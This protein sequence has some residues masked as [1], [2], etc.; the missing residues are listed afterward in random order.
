M[1]RFSHS[2]TT[3]KLSDPNIEMDTDFFSFKLINSLPLAIYTCDTDGYIR[4][5]NKAAIKLWGREPKIGADLWCG[6]WKIF[7]ANGEPLALSSCPMARILKEGVV[8]EGEEIIVQ[9]PDGTKRNVIPYPVLVFDSNGILKGAVNTLVDITEQKK[10]EEHKQML[11][12]IIESSHDAIIS[13][14]LKGIVNSWNREAENMFG[15]TAQ[16]VIGKHISIIIPLERLGEENLILSKISNGE[17]LDHFETVRITKDGRKISISLTVSPVRDEKGNVIGASKI[18]RDITNQKL[19]EEKTL[20]HNSNLNILNSMGKT[21]SVILDSQQLL[22]KVTDT[23]TEL[24]KAELGAFFYNTV[25]EKGEA[26]LLKTFSGTS[27]EAF[28]MFEIP[29]DTKILNTIF[30]GEEILRSDD[31]TKDLRFSNNYILKNVSGISYLAVPVFSKSG[32]IVGG[33]FYTHSEAGKF[34]IEHENLVNGVASHAVLALD[35][36]RLFEEVAALN[37][38][39]DEFIGLASHELKTP[40]TSISGYLQILEKTLSINDS[41]KVF[42]K[43]A[44][45]QINKLSGLISDLLDISK[46]HT[47]KLPFSFIVF[48]LLQ[49]IDEIK[50]LMQQSYPSHKIE[51]RAE[52]EKLIIQADKQRIEQVFINLISNAIKYSPN[53][54]KVY[55]HVISLDGKVKISIQDF[56][57][58]IKPEDQK[59]IFEKFYRVKGLAAHFSGLG[60]GLYISNEI[61]SRHNGKLYVESEVGVGS[62]FSFEIP[63]FQ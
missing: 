18:A 32:S 29:P 51:L 9:R 37:L 61:I 63:I 28:G 50:D 10:G 15:Y 25:D 30:Q 6:S 11:A 22:Q 48:D 45:Q 26:L 39:K 35:N 23:T 36:A 54:D 31:I 46:I 13:K 14:T 60:I 57:V 49:L 16:E 34:T 62:T 52:F 58:G 41:S 27:E 7:K 5:Y 44:N 56:G 42:V 33:L 38:K 53:A 21:L 20:R 43:K 12:A 4:S 8:V 1:T 17:K 2:E 40:V 55:I 24:I 19:L 59:Q 47:G 3:S